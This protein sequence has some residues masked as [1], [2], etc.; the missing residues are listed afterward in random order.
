MKKV[1]LFCVAFLLLM[2]L[3]SCTTS[4]S[5]GGSSIEFGKEIDEETMAVISPVTT[6]NAGEE[7]WFVFNNGNNYFNAEHMTLR[8][9]DVTTGEIFDEFDIVIHPEHDTY[10]NTYMIEDPGKYKVQFIIHG[11]TRATQQIIVQ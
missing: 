7:F 10:A 3:V 2:M 11:G 5:V 8:I 4:T 9:T 1:V 6:F